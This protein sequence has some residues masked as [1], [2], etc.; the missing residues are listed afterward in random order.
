MNTEQLYAE[1]GLDITQFK[2][3]L[4]TLKSDLKGL[5][6]Q[7]A[8]TT[9]IADL[10]VLNRKI[11]IVSDEITKIKSQGLNTVATTSKEART[12]VTGLSLAIQDLPFGFVGVQN[13][14][15]GI[16]QGFGK[17][18]T[19]SKGLK[20]FF[21][22]LGQSLKGPAGLYLGFSIVTSAVTVLAQKYGGLGNAIDALF[23]KQNKF[24]TELENAN[25][26]YQEFL[27]T[28]L[29]VEQVTNN[30]NASVS[31]QIAVITA[32]T[33][34][35]TDL[36][37]TEK[38]RKNALFQ[39]KEINKD[40]YDKLVAGKSSVEEI[41]RATKKYIE[42]LRLQ[43][44]VQ[45]FASEIADVDKQVFEQERLLKTAIKNRDAALK[46]DE[47]NKKVIASS[48][49]LGGAATGLKSNLG[50]EQKTVDQLAE[51]IF[52][53]N[54]RNQS[55]V[56]EIENATRALNSNIQATDGAAKKNREYL[57]TFKLSEEYKKLI[58]Y[59]KDEEKFARGQE[60][61]KAL[62]KDNLLLQEKQDILDQI[63]LDFPSVFE[64]YDI[65][66]PITE[67]TTQLKA[68]LGRLQESI[69]I[70]AQQN[71]KKFAGVELFGF[72]KQINKE[73]FD[74]MKEAEKAASAL[75]KKLY[76]EIDVFREGMFDTNDPE[77]YLPPGFYK[78]LV[79]A[80]TLK[81]IKVPTI[82]E[83]FP[84]LK[85][86]QGA[87]KTFEKDY[88]QLFQEIRPYVQQAITEP[89]EY[90]FDK[91]LS[92]AKISWKEF[93]DIA[94]ASLKRVAIQ[95]A[96]NAAITAIA[97]A[98]VPGSGAGVQGATEIIQSRRRNRGLLTLPIIGSGGSLN[99][100]QGGTGLS[101]EV[102]FVQRGA[103]LV[104]VLNRTN[105]NINRIG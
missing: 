42:T 7:R 97:N 95:L 12:A 43:A 67:L 29:S 1:L 37:T 18:S 22:S 73:F 30:A 52:N 48:A 68:A 47:A 91:V 104:G 46:Q 28:Q 72:A 35:A 27:K 54:N 78:A 77:N 17:L 5:E 65:K 99:G 66:T 8:A 101:G 59:Y 44:K 50:T 64:D 56:D 63:K 92:K 105:T 6:K 23:G 36:S 80:T 62:Q 9:A 94:V 14:L 81:G 2:K 38:E 82:N 31:G 26:A 16:I 10:D 83:V 34:A 39:L 32:L 70:E 75:S 103:D 49:K 71:Q 102:V 84:W 58:G 89:L 74:A 60:F 85:E 93:A 11:K 20:G 100:L 24:R 69:I 15:P 76:T 45:A 25:K 86:S 55:F 41:D 98:L 87:L 90:L 88:R 33:K 53:L 13:N 51:S 96:I 19:E 21:V 3:S 4:T 61:V 57:E 40:Y 79:A